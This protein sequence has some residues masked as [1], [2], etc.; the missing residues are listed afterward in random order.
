MEMS[1][2]KTKTGVCTGV[3]LSTQHPD[4]RVIS[5]CWAELSNF[6]PGGALM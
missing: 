4:N 5:G 2:F 6:Q 3:G 1:R